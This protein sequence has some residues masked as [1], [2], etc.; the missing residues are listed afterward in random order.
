MASNKTLSTVAKDADEIGAGDDVVVFDDNGAIVEAGFLCDVQGDSAE[1]RI[2]HAKFESVPLA[3]VAHP[4]SPAAEASR[5]R[6][7][8]KGERECLTSMYERGLGLPS[9]AGS[10]IGYLLLKRGL[11]GTADDALPGGDGGK[12]SITEAGCAAIGRPS[13]GAFRLGEPKH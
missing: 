5:L 4:D 1:I 12:V 11:L 3:T 9:S 10:R 13:G 8:T 2:G 6:P 7:L